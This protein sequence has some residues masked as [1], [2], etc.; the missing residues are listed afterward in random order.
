MKNGFFRLL[1]GLFVFGLLIFITQ[2]QTFSDVV[3][4]DYNDIKKQAE[5]GDID[6]QYILGTMYYDGDGVTQDYKQAAYWFTK[7]AKQ[8]DA[9]FQLILGMMYY[10]GQGVP[11]NYKQAAYWLTK[12]A[13][14][15]DARIQFFLGRMY[16]ITSRLPI[17]LL[18]SLNREMLMLNLF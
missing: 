16:R 5:K 15:G 7:G 11:Q 14:Q 2:N 6:A 1:V 12:C 18:R 8:G 9:R 3:P 4:V 13:E 10:D 17:G